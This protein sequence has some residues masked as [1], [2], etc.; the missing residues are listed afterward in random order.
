MSGIDN[1]EEKIE[2]VTS[3]VATEGTRVALSHS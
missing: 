1:G 3:N 2:R